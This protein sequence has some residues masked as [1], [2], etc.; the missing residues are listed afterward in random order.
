MSPPWT[1]SSPR[2][3]RPPPR[4]RKWRLSEVDPAKA[5]PVV[6]ANAA[7][8]EEIVVVIGGVGHNSARTRPDRVKWIL[9]PLPLTIA[10]KCTKGTRR[11]PFTVLPLKVARGRIISTSHWTQT[12]II[13]IDGAR[14]IT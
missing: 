13:K 6:V 9:D 3:P 11:K 12:I 7:L 4:Q 14:M 10:A 2:P 5:G 8:E 1:T